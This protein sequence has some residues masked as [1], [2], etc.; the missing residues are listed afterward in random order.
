[1]ETPKSVRFYLDSSFI[2]DGYDGLHGGILPGVA[3]E[4]DVVNH[5]AEEHC[6]TNRG[7]Y[8]EP[9]DKGVGLE[10]Y[11]SGG[12]LI[13]LRIEVCYH[14]NIQGGGIVCGRAF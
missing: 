14:I 2:C 11:H 3:M 5:L 12:V 1:M 6:D 9:G 10:V 7:D 8:Y 13:G 4:V